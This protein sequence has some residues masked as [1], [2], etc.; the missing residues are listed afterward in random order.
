M[1]FRRALPLAFAGFLLCGV[2]SAPGQEVRLLPGAPLFPRFSADALAHQLSL[3]RITDSR[4][5]I[6]AIGLAGPLLQWGDHVQAGA[7]ATVFSR[8]LKTPGHITVTTVDYRVDFP[9][10]LRLDSLRLRAALGHVSCHYADDAIEQMGTRSI[11]SV[12]DYVLVAAAWMAPGG[13]GYL[14]AVC[15]YHLEPA[16]GPWQLQGGAVW[17]LAEPAPWLGVIGAVDVK[18]KQDVGWGS[19]QSYQLGIRLAGGGGRS[20][21]LAWTHRRG[22]EERGQ[23][24]DRRTIFNQIGVVLELL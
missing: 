21:L 9:V 19:T 8:L 18:L 5:W 16:F 17:T 4:E 10:D 15:N 20:A 22:F 3:A 6:G 23:L 24:Y 2:H 13:H 7:G 1:T 14:S 12:R 11:S